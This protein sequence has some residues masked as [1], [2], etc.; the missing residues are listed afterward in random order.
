MIFCVS[1]LQ[2]TPVASKIVLLYDLYIIISETHNGIYPP[3]RCALAE[4]S[5]FIYIADLRCEHARHLALDGLEPVREDGGGRVGRGPAAPARPRPHAR[6]H[7]VRI[8]A[9]GWGSTR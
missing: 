9:P 5:Q 6:Q 1:L 7:R 8:H 2:S 3:V 4:W